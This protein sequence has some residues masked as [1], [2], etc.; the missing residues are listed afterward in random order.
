[1]I[2]TEEIKEKSEIS[3]EERWQIIGYLK[4]GKNHTECAEFF[5]HSRATIYRIHQK[6][7]T[8]G[9]VEDLARS[10]RP[11]SRNEEEKKDLLKTL[12]NPYISIRSV[13]ATE[14]LSKSTILNYAHD[15]G[16]NFKHFIEKPK[17]NELHKIKR[18]KF[19]ELNKHDNLDN[20]VFS[21]E[22]GFQLFRNTQGKWTT[23]NHLYIEKI[24]S[25]STLIIWGAISK[26]GRSKLYFF[27]YEERENQETYEEILD[28]YLFPFTETIFPGG[29]FIY[30][31]DNAPAHKGTQIME[32]LKSKIAYIP[33]IPPYSCDLNPIENIW[34]ILKDQVEKRQPKSREEL[35]QVIKEE[36][37]KIDQKVIVHCIE[38]TGKRI[39]EVFDKN[40]EF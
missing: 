36:W 3:Y 32:Y 39:K 24:S 4:A 11:P 8:T 16:L 2:G 21:D 28:S 15:V 34:S 7:Q 13:S 10:G 12:Q 26:Y 37:Y 30:Y 25:F 29:D 14:D 9:N 33:D 27:D 22:S 1:M 31:Q 19:C 17:L 40:G 23:E 6:Y 35:E 5:K 18:K 38:H 20:W